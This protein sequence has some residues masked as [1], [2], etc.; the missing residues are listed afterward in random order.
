MKL[1]VALTVDFLERELLCLADEAEDHEPGDEVEASVEADC[2]NVS[3][4]A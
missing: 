2:W 4:L 1:R 3:M